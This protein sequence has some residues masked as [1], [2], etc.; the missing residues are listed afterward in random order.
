MGK[1]QFKVIMNSSVL[2]YKY[3][4]TTAIRPLRETAKECKENT[5]MTTNENE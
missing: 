3:T 1:N 5:R 2:Y 4:G